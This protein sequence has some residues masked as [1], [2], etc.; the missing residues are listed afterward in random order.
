ME[1][2]TDDLLSQGPQSVAVSTQA[3]LSSKQDADRKELKEVL[4]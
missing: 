1:V 2:S 3:E 4:T